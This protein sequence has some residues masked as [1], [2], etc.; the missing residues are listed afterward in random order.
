[1]SQGILRIGD[2]DGERTRASRRPRLGLSSSRNPDPP[3]PSGPPRARAW[4]RLPRRAIVCLAEV[5]PDH[6][7]AADG[8]VPRLPGPRGRG[9][10]GGGAGGPG[11]GA[12]A[13]APGSATSWA[14]ATPASRAPSLPAGRPF[15][16]SAR[17][18]GGAFP[19]LDLRD[20]PQGSRRRARSRHDQHRIVR[21]FVTDDGHRDRPGWPSRRAASWRRAPPGPGGGR[22]R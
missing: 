5:P 22:R 12:E 7:L 16:V 10:G 13:P 9:P 21:L 18:Q 20:R 2:P 11:T 4:P 6:P 1:M 8:R 3:R 17:L 14:S 19:A 15:R